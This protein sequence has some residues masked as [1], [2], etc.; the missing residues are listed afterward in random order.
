[1]H[2]FYAKTRPIF[3][4]TALLQ[5]FGAIVA[6]GVGGSCHATNDRDYCRLATGALRR[7]LQRRICRRLNRP[8]WRGLELRLQCAAQRLV[9][10]ELRWEVSRYA[11]DRMLAN[12]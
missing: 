3:V 12:I 11:G 9:R 6:S 2:Q 8:Q 7:R 1:M 10:S 5:L 4:Q